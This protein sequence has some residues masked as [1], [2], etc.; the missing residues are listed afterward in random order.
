MRNLEEITGR[1]GNKLFQWA[2]IYSQFR[3]GKI[4]DTYVQD[5]RYFDKYKEDL[6]KIFG[7]GIGKL[8][9]VGIHI[10]RGDYVGNSFHADLSKDEPDGSFPKYYA[11]AIELFPDDNF[12]VVS[13]D[14][15][16][17][18]KMFGDIYDY[19]RFKI[20]EGRN[21]IEDFNTLASCERGIIMCN[22]SFSFWAAYLSTVSPQKI[23]APKEERWFN[24]GVIRSHL[25]ENWIR[26]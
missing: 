9:Y 7:E 18:K 12:L 19:E 23:V 8:P 3:E 11:K 2:Y 6:R 16:Y 4:P 20:V 5:Y 1:L 14:T 17:A 22:S 25:P 26:I 21:E 10:R 15:E 13:D 24:D